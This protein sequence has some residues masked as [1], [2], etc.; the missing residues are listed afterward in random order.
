M[1]RAM[2]VCLL[3][4]AAGCGKDGFH[5]SDLKLPGHSNEPACEEFEGVIELFDEPLKTRRQVKLD[6]AG[7]YV[8]HGKAIAWYENGQKA[9]E[10]T[11]K[12]DKPDGKTFAWYTSGKKKMH[13]QSADGMATGVWTEWHESG[14]KKSEGQ[15]LEGERH[16]Q[17]SFFD[18]GGEV[19]ELV[20]YRGGKRIGVVENPQKPLAR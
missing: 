5:V 16:G 1:K 10:M 12:N 13:G 3:F 14:A 2:I 4:A 7:N 8:H 19:I 6:A 20:E 15:Y 11:F 17:W 18:D 9:G